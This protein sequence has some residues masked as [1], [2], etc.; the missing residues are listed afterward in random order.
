MTIAKQVKTFGPV[1]Y[2]EDGRKYRIT[3]TVCH[4]DSCR[5]G[6]NTFSI[7]GDIDVWRNGRWAEDSGGTV[8]TEIAEHFPELAPHI[9]WHLT[10]TDGPMHYVANTLYWLGYCGWPP[11]TANLEYARSSAVWPDMP[12]SFLCSSNGNDGGKGYVTQQLYDRLPALLEAFKHDV[13]SL[14]LVY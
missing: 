7:T 6:H 11:G 1:E 2:T 5:N 13:E 3:A 10:S 14:G 9:K 4:D 8:H 12:E